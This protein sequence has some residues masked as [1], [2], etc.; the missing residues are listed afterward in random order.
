MHLHLYSKVSIHQSLLI[1]TQ[2][3]CHRFPVV[4]TLYEVLIASID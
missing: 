2:K 1:V 4:V 3:T